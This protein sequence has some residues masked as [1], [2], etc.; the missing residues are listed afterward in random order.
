MTSNHIRIDVSYISRAVHI[1][2]RYS[3]HL[4]AYP[5]LRH[6]C[7]R[8]R[9]KWIRPQAHFETNI[10]QGWWQIKYAVHRLYRVYSCVQRDAA[11][12]KQW[13]KCWGCPAF[14]ALWLMNVASIAEVIVM[15]IARWQIISWD[16]KVSQ[17]TH[18][19]TIQFDLHNCYHCSLKIIKPSAGKYYR[20]N[21]GI[22]D[23]RNNNRVKRHMPQ[24]F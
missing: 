19:N 2:I 21:L 6:C 13:V 20:Y 16:N 15:V 24:H 10:Q 11:L 14:R 12:R 18:E 9:P 5:A 4:K 8:H 17:I 22:K 23:M 1:G 7:L 3:M